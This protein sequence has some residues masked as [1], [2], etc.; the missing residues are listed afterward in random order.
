MG[1]DLTAVCV[2]FQQFELSRFRGQLFHDCIRWSS[3]TFR[4]T[5]L[6]FF[7]FLRLLH[8]IQ[9]SLYLVLEHRRCCLVRPNF[10]LFGAFFGGLARVL[11]WCCILLGL[12]LSGRFRRLNLVAER[13]VVA[14]G[15]LVSWHDWLDGVLNLFY[16]A[17]FSLL[18]VLRLCFQLCLFL[19][20][21]FRLVCLSRHRLLW[22]FR[23]GD[24]W[25]TH[26][27]PFPLLFRLLHLVQPS[28]DL[29]LELR[30]FGRFLL[31]GLGW[32]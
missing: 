3:L 18:L 27:Y 24:L 20:R 30:F 7:F 6:F 31:R 21:L 22:F 26:G 28:L 11:I 17:A 1:L 5:L 10:V 25:R 15:A 9:P 19:R 13:V 32:L 2:V 4:H 12:L 8:L 14:H 29:V 16:P 23:F